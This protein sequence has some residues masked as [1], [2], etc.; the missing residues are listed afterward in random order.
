M[1]VVSP[2]EADDFSKDPALPVRANKPT[3]FLEDECHGGGILT[4][5]PG[6]VN[7]STRS[8]E[9]ERPRDK[10]IEEAVEL[11]QGR[12]IVGSENE[13]PKG[14]RHTEGFIGVLQM[15]LKVIVP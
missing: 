8:R 14:I 6:E 10:D 9:S 5:S 3:V 13:I 2:P 7:S 12:R 4:T 15:M 1:G 11:F